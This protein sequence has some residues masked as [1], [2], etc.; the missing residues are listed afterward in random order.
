MKTI[1]VKSIQ[2]VIKFLN[3]Y[4]IECTVEDNCGRREGIISG[5]IKEF[6]SPSLP[7]GTATAEEMLIKF[8]EYT[9]E[10]GL[11]NANFA[12][13][14]IANRFITEHP[15]FAAKAGK[16]ERRIVGVNYFAEDLLEEEKQE[17]SGT[18]EEI[19]DKHIGERISQY[20]NSDT[21]IGA[22]LTHKGV[23]YQ[24]ILNAM[25]EFAASKAGWSNLRD[26]LIKYCKWFY[27][28]NYDLELDENK[29]DKY[30]NSIQ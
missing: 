16:T 1:E 6:A 5:R 20:I 22:N 25:H 28:E 30:L 12:H 8:Q 9:L 10:H 24:Y 18:A 4:V 29:I 14:Y 23:F 2:D 13:A 17:K 26:E 11:L 19:L 21:G 3:D 7:S 15:E 27:G